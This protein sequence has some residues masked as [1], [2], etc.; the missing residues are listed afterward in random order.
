MADVARA[1]TEGE[2][3]V[4][5]YSLLEAVNNSSD[6]AHTAWLIFLAIMAYLMI[7]VAGVTHKDLLLETPVALPIMQVS[8]QQ[9]LFFEF[10]P[11]ILV[12]FHLGVISQLV[13][14]AR[15]T[16]EF[17]Y[18]VRSLE[19]TERRTHPLRLE[20]HNF[21]FVQAIAG[22]HRSAVMSVFLHAMSW[23]TLVGLPIVIL[24]FFQI[25]YLP[26]HD[27]T[28]TWLHRICVVADIAMLV[29]IGVFLVRSESSFFSAFWRTTVSNPVSFLATIAL[30]TIV[31]FFSFLVA[32]VPGEG[33]EKATGFL[34]G[35]DRR[36]EASRDPRASVAFALPFMR[37]RADGALLGR[38]YRHLVVSDA[39]LV[40][41][42]D[43][44]PEEVSISL[45]GRDLR[46]AILDRTDLHRSD[47]TGAQL[48]GAS[49]VGTNL[50][51]VRIQC[52]DLTRLILSEDRA[53]AQ[54]VDARGANFTRANL[55]RA[56]M[57]GIDLRGA[58]LE[59]ANLESADLSHAWATGASFASA[60]LDKAD[61]TG[62]IQLQGANLL[63]ASLHGAEMSGAQLQGADL[64]SA[65]LVGAVLSIANLSGAT[66]RDAD[67]DGADLQYASLHKAD[68]SGARIRAADLRGARVWMTQPPSRDAL[69]LADLAGL[70]IVPP[71]AAEGTA[72]RAGVER[73]D[74][75]RV[76]GL[77]REAVA[78][79]LEEAEARKWTG[80]SESLTW[81]SY[82]GITASAAQETYAKDLS[83]AL[84]TTACKTRYA[85]GG[86]ATGL[87][88]RAAGA[89]FRGTP[90]AIYERLRGKEC[91]ATETVSKRAMERLS[92]AVDSIS[93]K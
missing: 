41:D 63:I 80:G 64:S 51:L 28:T 86:V 89:A 29:L 45:R 77:V 54:C 19:L 55:F 93:G 52:A 32:T 79:V 16:L 35:A 67:L 14:L 27:V 61:M 43:S 23:L 87:A 6:S 4:N 26:Y 7:A 70:V 47:M 11:V 17:D 10:A 25:T 49:F 2:T 42:R 84:A 78:P 15:K 12:L 81:Q 5:P 68:L 13:L 91:A 36:A 72:L 34:T 38:F 59:E 39:D 21:F 57:A 71:E 9:G 88:K 3:P 53:K 1:G 83:D 20:V 24:L 37:S 82:V 75:A 85:N 60:R 48:E 76:K 40:H 50:S 66:M 90:A 92:A 18:A 31:I 8:I 30:M 33:L 56:R 58:K 65:S 74:N 69:A 62:G 44:T 22:P 46:F 73:I